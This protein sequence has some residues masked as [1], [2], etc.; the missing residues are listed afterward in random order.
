M[1]RIFFF[2]FFVIVIQLI[3]WLTIEFC[4]YI[5]LI[6]PEVVEYVH[7]KIENLPFFYLHHLDYTQRSHPDAL[8]CMLHNYAYDFPV[9]SS[10]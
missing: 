3:D 9:L 5:L 2:Y 8:V 7:L 1:I 4:F 6:L 10:L